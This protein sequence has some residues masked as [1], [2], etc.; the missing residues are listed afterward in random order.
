MPDKI[1]LRIKTL[2]I[3]YNSQLTMKESISP[4]SMKSTVKLIGY[5]INGFGNITIFCQQIIHITAPIS[6]PFTQRI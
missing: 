6:F 4:C 3:F 5:I 1:Q 2:S